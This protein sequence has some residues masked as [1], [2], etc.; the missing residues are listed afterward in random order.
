MHAWNCNRPLTAGKEDNRVFY[1]RPETI[2]LEEPRIQN[3]FRNDFIRQISTP[4][5]PE[6]FT[7]MADQFHKQVLED[8]SDQSY[9]V[10]VKEMMVKFYK[11]RQYKLQHKRHKLLQR[12]AHHALT[13]ELVDKVSLKFSPNYSKLQFELEN[14]V[15]RHQRLDG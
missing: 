3:Q 7:L 12:W 10:T 4:P 15:K 14:C 1:M 5:A 9:P 6:P 8:C 11:R 2:F 13:S